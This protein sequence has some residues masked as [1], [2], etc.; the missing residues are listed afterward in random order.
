MAYAAQWKGM[1]TVYLYI[2][3]TFHKSTD[4]IA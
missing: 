4:E 1:G 3:E 2:L